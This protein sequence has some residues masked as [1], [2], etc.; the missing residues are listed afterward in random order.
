MPNAHSAYNVYQW[1]RVS[2]V[3]IVP[4]L[5]AG[6]ARN[7]GSTPERGNNFVPSVFCRPCCCAG[8]FGDLPWKKKRRVV[9]L[10]THL[11]LV[12]RLRI[13]GDMPPLSNMPSGTALYGMQYFCRDC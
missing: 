12:G 1:S 7:H 11:H 8:I 10:T 6:R 4:R 3:G 9:K 2:S 5:K 13:N